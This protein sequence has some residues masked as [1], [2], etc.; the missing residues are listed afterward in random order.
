MKNIL[1]VGS[2]QAGLIAATTIK[3]VFKD[4]DVTVVS[5]KDIPPIGVGE[6]STEQWSSYEKRVGI[7][8]QDLIKASMATFKYGIRFLDWTNHTPDYFHSISGG[9]LFANTGTFNGVYNYIHASGRKLT[10][11]LAHRGLIKGLVVDTKEPWR[12]TNQFHFDSQKLNEFLKGHALTMGIN[13]IEAEVEGLFR[14]SENGDITHVLTSHGKIETDFVVDASGF[15]QIILKELGDIHQSSFG[16]YLPCDSAL[17]FQTP[18]NHK[19]KPFTEAKALSAGWHWDIPTYE[20]RGHGYVFSSRYIDEDYAIGEVEHYIDEPVKNTRTIKYEPYKVQNSWQFN[21]VAVG[22]ASNFVEPLEATSIAATIEQSRLICSYLPTYEANSGVHQH[23]YLKVFDSMFDNLLTMVSM[24]YVSDR[25]DSPM[26]A[27]QQDAPR[28]E[29][30]HFLI[31][32]F[33]HRGPEQHDIPYTGYELFGPNHFWHVAQGQ[34]LI[35]RAGSQIGIEAFGSIAPSME[36]VQETQ[37][38]NAKR[39]ELPHRT[40]LA[41]AH[42]N[43]AKKRGDWNLN[44]IGGQLAPRLEK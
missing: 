9:Q 1:I 24:H 13:F 8:R 22:L 15:K 18:G 23:G 19:I 25:R 35:S 37:T 41:R 12:Q 28:T 11:S 44:D 34:G 42:E 16:D 36:M 40:V 26:W 32:L 6:G 17:V 20:R 30:L 5:S 3:S 2:G 4:F 31:E 38:N 29:L 21:C 27:D 14:N 39:P 7:N 43:F 33:K 10:P